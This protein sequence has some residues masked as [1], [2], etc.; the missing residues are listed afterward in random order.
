M[1]FTRMRSR[2]RTS[3][4]SIRV[5]RRTSDGCHAWL[6]FGQMRRDG[7]R[8]L[9]RSIQLRS[10]EVR[11]NE[12]HAPAGSARSANDAGARSFAA[13]FCSLMVGLLL[14]VTAWAQPQQG[15]L[16]DRVI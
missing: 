4:S 10:N 5:A 2:T 15:V 16:I 1:I 12:S 11:P 9:E 8:I 7:R 6:S 13:P 3:S 14:S